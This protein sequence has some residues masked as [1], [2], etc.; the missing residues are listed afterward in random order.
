M[1]EGGWGL[2]ENRSKTSSSGHLE[3]GKEGMGIGDKDGDEDRDEHRAGA[4]GNG[5]ANMEPI[6]TRGGNCD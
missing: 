2:G 1:G 4:R 5:L 6:V 3:A